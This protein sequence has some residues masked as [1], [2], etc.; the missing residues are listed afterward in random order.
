[1]SIVRAKEWQKCHVCSMRIAET[2]SA[3]V[4]TMYFVF[5]SGS[6]S[7]EEIHQNVCSV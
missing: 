3:V 5:I 2:A 6:G 1:M 7:V 4:F